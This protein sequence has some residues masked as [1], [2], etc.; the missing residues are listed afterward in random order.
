MQNTGFH[1]NAEFSYLGASSGSLIQCEC[2]GK[3]VLEIKH[4]HNSLLRN[5]TGVSPF[6]LFWEKRD[7]AVC[8]R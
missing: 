4:P 6:F 5:K 2:H 1:I 8:I 7:F 3:G